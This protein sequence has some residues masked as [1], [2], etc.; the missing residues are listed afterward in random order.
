MRK[1]ATAEADVYNYL[2]SFFERYYAEGDFVSQRRYASRGRSAYLIPY[3]GEEVKLHWANADQ[4]YVKT[5]DN[6][7]AYAFTVSTGEHARRARLEISAATTERDNVNE[8]AG[9]QRRFVLAAGD[10]A[11]AVENGELVVRFE[12]RPLTDGEKRRWP[13]N[14]TTQQAR[15]NSATYERVLH[16]VDTEWLNPDDLENGD[17]PRLDRALAR[18]RRCGRLSKRTE[19]SLR[20]AGIEVQTE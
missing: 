11:V 15:I 1:D 5:A 3:D 9:R 14:G 17:E 13:G 19:T 7:A 2:A 10:R 8:T 20:N 4:Y 18:V 6:Y 16:A 12:H